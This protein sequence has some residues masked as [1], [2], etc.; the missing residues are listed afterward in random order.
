MNQRT[1]LILLVAAIFVLGG[2]VIGIVSYI[3]SF[4]YVTIRYDNPY[5]Q[6]VVELHTTEAGDDEHDM[7][8][9]EKV[10]DIKSGERLRLKKGSY[11]LVTKGES[12][13]ENIRFISVGSEEETVNYTLQLSVEALNTLLDEQRSFIQQAVL[14]K[15]P[16]ITTLYS[17]ENEKILQ[18]GDW[19]VAYLSYKG[20]DDT[21]RDTLRI[22]ARNEDDTW[23]VT[24]PPQI[25][26]S[27]T[28]YPAIPL[29]VLKYA[30]A[31]LPAPKT[32]AERIQ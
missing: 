6:A 32:A 7:K 1:Q 5:E 15:Y 29:E 23:K 18:Q 14:Q 12:Y 13:A 21:V 3:T 22:I 25:A 9:A 26:I 8:I 19:Y 11:A 28:E 20:P 17:F 4:Q 10:Q 16:D 2:A 30:N 27:R 31:I 24:A